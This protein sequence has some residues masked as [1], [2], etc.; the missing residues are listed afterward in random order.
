MARNSAPR[1]TASRP[2]EHAPSSPSPH[3]PLWSLHICP[4]A[5][6]VKN[7]SSIQQILYKI[8]G[9]ALKNTP[10]NK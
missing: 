3:N 1:H 10:K 8:G 5:R 2:K 4:M 6:E 7:D 9:G